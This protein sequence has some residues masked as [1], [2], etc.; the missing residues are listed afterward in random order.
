MKL[1]IAI[2]GSLLCTTFAV[3]AEEIVS[4]ESKAESQVFHIRCDNGKTTTI[5]YRYPN[6]TYVSEGR[7]FTLY[8]LAV[9]AVCNEKA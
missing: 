6:E 7:T 5:E 1:H 8:R 4:R 3:Q 9:A 2:L